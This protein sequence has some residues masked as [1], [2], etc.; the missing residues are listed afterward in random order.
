MI[1][2]TP[3]ILN[4]WTPNLALKKDEVTKVP[5]WVKMH[6]V[7]VVAYSEDGLSL[8]ATQIGK[9][10]MLDAFTS[11]MCE[12]PWGRLGY[13]RALIEVSAD[14]PLKKDVI[15][16]VPEED[17]TGH[18]LEK[19]CLEY[20]WKPPVFT[21]VNK[22]NKKGKI[23]QKWQ[24][25][26][27]EGIKL[28]KPR[29]SFSY[30]N[31]SKPSMSKPLK[32]HVATKN[33]FDALGNQG[34]NGIEDTIVS[35]VNAVNATYEPAD[36]GEESEVEEVNIEHST[37]KGSHVEISGLAN[38]CSKVFRSWDW[39]SNANLCPKGC[40]IILGWNVD[41]HMVN[42]SPWILLG[43]FNVALNMEDVS[44]GS[45]FMNSAMN[46]FKE[47]VANLEVLDV[48]CSG[49]HYTWN[50]K[51]ILKK[52][53]DHSPAVLK[54]PTLV[55]NKPKP[56]KYYNFLAYKDMFGEVVSHHWNTTI[57][58]NLHDR[59]SKLRKEL[60]EVQIAIDKNPN[61]STLRDEEAVYIQ[62]FTDVKIDEECF[63][64]QKAKVD[65]L[66][67]G[68]AN[69]AY[70]YKTFKSK[71][72]RSRITSV[73]DAND[74]EVTGPS[75][76]D[77]SDSSNT[78]MVQAISNEEIKS[79]M[80]NIGDDRASGPDGFTSAFFKKGWDT[81]GM[82]VPTPLKVN[83]FRPIS[84][85]NVL[86]N[87][88]S[89]ILTNRIIDSIKEVLEILSIMPFL[90]GE[91]L[92]KYL[93]VPLISSR[94]LNKDCK[95]LVEKE[96]NRIVLVIPKGILQDIQQLIRGFLWCNGEYKRGRAKVAWEDIGLPK[97]EGGLGIRSL[98]LFNI[99]LMTTHIWNIVSNKESLWVRWI[100][101]YKLNG[102]SIWDEL[103]ME[104][105]TSNT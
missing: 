66:E 23:I 30:T 44:V 51:P 59:I 75:V 5:V 14:K 13:A 64:K 19:I 18:T 74:I 37:I 25:R 35:D 17:G 43:D 12:D 16:A 85:C 83:D 6:K 29:P 68:D 81:I 78:N 34:D 96:K 97:H 88:I 27:I 52:I 31:P 45:S 65:W 54:F 95:I 26:G 69:S 99:A 82:D 92:V 22:K 50:Q 15:M 76:P 93:G 91:L 21:T 90:E 42:N 10:I 39:T 8:I 32:T 11:S 86:Y 87:C 47:C 98:E 55:S 2:N 100:H 102:R 61:D 20:E 53:S 89:K 3:L 56:F 4:K 41:V 77:V 1:R 58:G 46:E 60:D 105:T 24:P 57:A 104:K 48:N 70:F 9:P 73:L 71:N 72:H 63:L 36:D 103:G 62:A 84:C 40:R 79:A 94:L 7:P 28:N 38:V 33:Q 67:V 101:T 80:F 49:L